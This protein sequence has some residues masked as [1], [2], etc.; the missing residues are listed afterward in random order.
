MSSEDAKDWL[1]SSVGSP[2]VAIGSAAS[3]QIKVD[4]AVP[5]P[6][7]AYGPGR[8]P[9][10]PFHSMEVGDSFLA[11]E[12]SAGYV[13]VRASTYG[14]GARKKFVTRKTAEGLRVWRTE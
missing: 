13:K 5:I 14:A 11:D 6:L 8:P 12:L 2:T 9:K 3:S 10:Y 1:P 4:K 7:P